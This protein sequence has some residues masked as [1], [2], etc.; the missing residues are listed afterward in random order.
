MQISNWRGVSAPSN[1]NYVNQAFQSELGRGGVISLGKGL[2]LA[3]NSYWEELVGSSEPCR[4]HTFLPLNKGSSTLYLPSLTVVKLFRVSCINAI[5]FRPTDSLI[6]PLLPSVL[7]KGDLWLGVLCCETRAVTSGLGSQ[8]GKTLILWHMGKQNSWA[9]AKKKKKRN[10]NVGCEIE[11]LQPIE[12]LP[13]EPQ[14]ALR[15]RVMKFFWFW[16]F[17]HLFLF[18]QEDRNKH[19]GYVWIKKKNLKRLHLSYSS[20][21][22]GCIQKRIR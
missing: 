16:V 9:A 8:K 10:R 12:S 17:L 6:V 18:G 22:I 1:T 20:K 5:L 2:W 19:Q 3:A 13:M 14:Y 4:V 11:E 7:F 21:N 15:L